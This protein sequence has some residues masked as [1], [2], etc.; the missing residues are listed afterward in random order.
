MSQSFAT[1]WNQVD[2]THRLIWRDV[3]SGFRTVVRSTLAVTGIATIAAAAFVVSRP[4]IRDV[5]A[6]FGAEVKVAIFGVEPSVASATPGSE[7]TITVKAD[8]SNASPKSAASSSVVMQLPVEQ[9]AATE[10]LSR[11]YRLAPDA[12]GVFVSEAF[13]VAQELRLDPLLVLAVM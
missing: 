3:S 2:S 4:E 8:E 13:R 12:I 6:D 7:E 9:R 11:K 5:V 10:Y 1:T